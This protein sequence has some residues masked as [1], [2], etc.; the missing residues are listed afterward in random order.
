MTLIQSYTNSRVGVWTKILWVQ[1][2]QVV[3]G[4]TLGERIIRSN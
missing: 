4:I 2:P 3:K 1:D